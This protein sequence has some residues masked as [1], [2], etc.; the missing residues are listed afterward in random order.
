MNNL[1]IIRMSLTLAA[2]AALAGC[3]TQRETFT[4]HN[5]EQVWTALVAAAQT[6][7]Y[8][9]PTAA[10]RWT[11]RENNVWVD[12]EQRRIEIDRLLEREL[13]QPGAQPMH[14]QRHWKFQV[15]LEQDQPPTA[16]F[17][18]RELGV[19][20]HAWDE[21]NRYFADVWE[22]LGGPAPANLHAP[23]DLQAAPDAQP[24]E[25]SRE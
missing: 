20:A 22:L 4:G 23:L 14:Q 5:A 10:D 25:S 6:P 17:V 13:H 7:D 2:L 11:L 9:G 18:S 19:P 1:L 16:A 21:A 24:T 3:T 12:Q 8:A 15:R